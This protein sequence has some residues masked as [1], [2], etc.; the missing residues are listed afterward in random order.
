MARSVVRRMAQVTRIDSTLQVP[1]PYGSRAGETSATG[2]LSKGDFS[3]KIRSMSVIAILQQLSPA[4]VCISSRQCALILP[5]CGM[6]LASS[7]FMKILISTI[8]FLFCAF[9]LLLASTNPASQQLLITAKQQASLFQHDVSP[10]ELDIDFLVQVQVPTQGHL[11]LK[12]EA[13]ERWWRKIVVGDFE[14]IDIRNGDR[15]YTSRNA[16]FTPVRIRELISLLQFAEHSEGLQVKKQ[17]QR[18]ERGVEMTCLQVGRA[19]D[20]GEPHEVCM[21]SASHEILSDEWKEPPDER[22][23]QQYAEYFDFRTHRYP[24]KLELFVNGISAI[25]A[26]VGSLTT[27]TLDQTL[28]V[29]PRGAIERRQCA[30]MKHAVPVKTPDPMYPKSA[31]E[32]R[33]M[34]DTIVSMTV[35][36]DGSVSD[37]QLVGSATRSMD[38]ATLQTLKGWKFKPAMCGAEP[39]VSDIEVVVSFRLQ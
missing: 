24:R 23:R 34:G 25:T 21:N 37:I 9:H 33:L 19:T 39:V 36:A 22:R 38:D 12:W 32:N 16:P 15:L 5:V 27:A 11:S 8:L 14:Q 10:F 20:R 18:V 4:T 35:L 31:S 1:R 28:L 29:A 30:D 7:P 17:K 2:L 6:I 13:D 26:H 3:P